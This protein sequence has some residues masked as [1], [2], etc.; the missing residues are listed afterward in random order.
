M[1]KIDGSELYEY[2]QQLIATTGGYTDLGKE[3]SYGRGSGC[4]FRYW[5]AKIKGTIDG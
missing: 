1:Y 5:R 2:Q 4:L 3:M